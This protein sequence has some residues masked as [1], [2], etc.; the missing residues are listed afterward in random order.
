[1]HFDFPDGATPVNDC[2]G[3]LISWVQ[4]MSDLNRVEA[5]NVAHAQRKYLRSSPNISSW[6]R[7]KE[8][9]NIHRSMFGKVWDWAGKQRTSVTSIGIK[10]AL[11]AAHMAELFAEVAYW[12]KSEMNLSF[13]E[14]SARIHHRLVAIHPFENGNG[15]FSRLIADRCLLSWRC[16]HPIW[17][18]ELSQEGSARKQYIQ[19][20]KA[21]DKGNYDLLI[22]FME[23]HGA[24]SA[25]RPSS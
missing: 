20:L 23:E 7:M 17:P 13:L 18:T 9:Q 15:R 12:E 10:P 24:S 14:K 4:T 5:E 6:F 11:I 3:L 21:A 22:E 25:G 1:M 19:S 16:Q 8:L 2:S